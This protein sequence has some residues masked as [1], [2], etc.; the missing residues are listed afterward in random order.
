MLLAVYCACIVYFLCFL[1]YAAVDVDKIRECHRYIIY[2]KIVF[3]NN[4]RSKIVMIVQ[5]SR[6]CCSVN[7]KYRV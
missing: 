6:C 7:W 2:I 4:C 5:F 3:S 1:V